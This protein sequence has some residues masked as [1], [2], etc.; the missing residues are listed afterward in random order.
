MNEEGFNVDVSYDKFE[1]E[2]G[3]RSHVQRRFDLTLLFRYTPSN[4]SF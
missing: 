2:T 4:D 3:A 1:A